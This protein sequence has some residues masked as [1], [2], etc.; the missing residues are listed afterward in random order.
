MNLIPNLFE[1]GWRPGPLEFFTEDG[2]INSWPGSGEAM[3]RWHIADK[4]GLSFGNGADEEHLGETVPIHIPDPSFYAQHRVEWLLAVASGERLGGPQPSEGARLT[5]RSNGHDLGIVDY[6]GGEGGPMLSRT[7]IFAGR[8]PPP[9]GRRHQAEFP[10]G[11]LELASAWGFD[12]TTGI[13][14][15]PQGRWR[16]LDR[17]A[18][19]AGEKV[20]LFGDDAYPYDALAVFQENPA[21]WLILAGPYGERG[22][23]MMPPPTSLTARVNGNVLGTVNF[24]EQFAGT[25]DMDFCVYVGEGSAPQVKNLS[26]PKN[27]SLSDAAWSVAK[28][29]LRN[30]RERLSD[31]KRILRRI[32]DDPS[33]PSNI[34]M[35]SEMAIRHLEYI[36]EFIDSGSSEDERLAEVSLN[37]LREFA[38]NILHK[39]KN[40]GPLIVEL[41]R[42]LRGIFG[43]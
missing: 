28:G 24:I 42:L 20:G 23:E 37:W 35:M 32:C 22:D 18:A 29:T 1:E 15:I 19:E 11:T 43:P 25:H 38:K 2:E 36:D 13:F 8:G 7:E 27:E 10:E 40:Y 4:F 33:Y 14:S 5:I 6:I 17:A 41:G 3:D 26:A 30:R 9:G 31:T 16:L 12:D 21:D 39:G 34:I